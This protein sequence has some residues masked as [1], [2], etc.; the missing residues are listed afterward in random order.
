MHR[1]LKRLFF[2]GASGTLLAGS[3]M[4]SAVAQEKVEEIVV[5][6]SSIRGKQ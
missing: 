6:G 1:S 4:Q 2:V 5:T 3:F